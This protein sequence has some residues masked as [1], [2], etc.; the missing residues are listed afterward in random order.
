VAA[1]ITAA[2]QHIADREARW[3]AHDKARGPR[4]QI[5]P[6][7]DWADQAWQQSRNA[8]ARARAAAA[9]KARDDTLP[10]PF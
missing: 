10:P 2:L 7:E 8:A 9:A 1:D 4:R 6:D 5:E 3:A